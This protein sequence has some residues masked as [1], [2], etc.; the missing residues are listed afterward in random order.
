MSFPPSPYP[1]QWCNSSFFTA[2]SGSS[3]DAEQ[4]MYLETDGPARQIE[5]GQQHG[6]NYPCICG[7]KAA[8]HGNLINCYHQEVLDGHNTIALSINSLEKTHHGNINP[9]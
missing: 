4:V 9:F 1:G 5:A 8:Q 6:G 7:V 2:L 3:S